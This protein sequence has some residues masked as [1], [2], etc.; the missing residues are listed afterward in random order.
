MFCMS[1]GKALPDGALSCAS[2]GAP[3]TRQAAPPAGNAYAPPNIPA[4][5]SAFAP[6][7][8]SRAPG[9][10]PSGSSFPWLIIG[11][12][13]CFGVVVVIGIISAI[14]LP[15]LSAARNSS[16]ATDCKNRMK[17][18]GVYFSLYES[19]FK[20]YPP[21]LKSIWRPD[22]ATDPS[23]FMCPVNGT[24][25]KREFSST[26][27]MRYEDFASRVTV[28]YRFPPDG[29][30]TRPDFLMAWDKS[31]HP[32]GRRTVLFFQGRVDTLD[33]SEF[34]RAQKVR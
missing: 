14:T 21:G 29:D 28:E 8:A 30:A 17:Q 20:A 24:H 9:A 15:A 25:E 4:G 32:D 26:S 6:S 11:L 1:C 2:C 33:Q 34:E 7:F 16:R 22:M 27:A 31:P 13:G 3:V 18:L 23:I 12:V 10:P 5:N 19:K